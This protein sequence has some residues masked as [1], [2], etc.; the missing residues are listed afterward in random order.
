MLNWVP[1]EFR[2]ETPFPVRNRGAGG[3]RSRLSFPAKAPGGK[4]PAI[5]SPLKV[6]DI[7]VINPF[8]AVNSPLPESSIP[9]GKLASVAWYV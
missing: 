2:N 8:V 5:A 4:R 7:P 3:M 1:A 9:F 6:P